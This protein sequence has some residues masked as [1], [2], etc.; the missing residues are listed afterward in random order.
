[1]RFYTQPH[2]FD[3]GL[4]LHARS[5]YVCMVNQAGEMLV[6]RNRPAAPEPSRQAIAP[7]R[8]DGVV[9]VEGIFT[10]YWRADRCAQAGLPCVLGHALSMTA[11]HGGQAKHDTSAS[12][13]MAALRRGGL[14]P[15]A[16]GDP[17]ARRAPRD[18]RRRR[19]PRARKRAA[20]RAHGPHTNRQDNLPAIGNKMASK[21]N[22]EGGAARLAD[23]A[24]HQRS[25]VA[26]ALIRDAAARLR[27]VDLTLRNTA[28]HHD[29]NP[30]SLRHTGPGLG[31]SRRLVW[32]S[33]IHAINRV[34]T[35]QEF[36][37]ACRLVNWAKEAAGQ[38]VGPAGTNIGKAHLPWAV[39]D[40]AV[41]CRRDPPP[42]QNDLARL[43]Q[44]PDT[45]HALPVLAQKVARAV[46]DRRKR[47]GACEKARCCPR[48]WRGADAPGAS[49]DTQGMNLP[50]ALDTAA[51]LASW[52]AQARIGRD[53]LSPA[54]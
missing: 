39:S 29:A 32:R 33:A 50:D 49:R 52:N 30:L 35:G 38:R 2:Q 15:Q 36:V 31:K 7:C 10:W 21:A 9:W 40:A 28:Q 3:G 42:A 27:D 1:M 54:L 6:H 47:P 34:P 37:S 5:L 22:R 12:Q 45:G 24:G 11:I 25:A 8:A 17:A 51:G 16:S 20:L 26:R 41:L 13:T 18:R 44:K 46:Y 4:D 23:P 14:L 48:E 43:G 53:P 19:R